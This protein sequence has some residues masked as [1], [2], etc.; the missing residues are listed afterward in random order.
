MFKEARSGFAVSGIG[1]RTFVQA[2]A[3]APG[4]WILTTAAV[5]GMYSSG[6]LAGS[7]LRTGVNRL[8]SGAACGCKK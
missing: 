2:G 6:V 5:T 8:A 1:S 3:T 7:I 4:S